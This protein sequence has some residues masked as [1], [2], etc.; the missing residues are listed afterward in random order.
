MAKYTVLICDD[1]ESVHRSM[2]T[3]LN[4]EKI[5][6]ISVYDG[7]SA[8]RELRGNHVDIVLLDVMLPGMDGV[9][10][11]RNIRKSSDV[12]II[13]LSAKSEEIDRVV[14]LEMGADDYVPKPFSP[15]EVVIRIKMALKRIYLRSEPKVLTLAEL[16]VLPE[17][18]QVFI[19]DQK[20]DMTQKETEV[21]SMLVSNPGIALTREHLLNS[22][23]GF[24]YLGETR[25]V[26]SLVKRLRQKLPTE[27]VHFMIRS[28]YGVGY[29]IE[30]LS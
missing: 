22:I 4:A 13:M 8:L 15:R 14:G 21:L 29:K 5:D 16:T 23:W 25:V 11:C 24:E 1:N 17:S 10:V 26:D 18:Y 7:E 19:G 28:V 27:G 9:E 6:V 20:I 3:Y 30:E 2:V 12:Y